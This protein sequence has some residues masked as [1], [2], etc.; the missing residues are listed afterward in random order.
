VRAAAGP[1]PTPRIV[2][3]CRSVNAHANLNAVP[4]EEFAPASVD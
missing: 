1:C 4:S 3:R 2:E